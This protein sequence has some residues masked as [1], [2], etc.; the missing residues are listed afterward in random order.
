ML[1]TQAVD[2]DAEDILIDHAGHGRRNSQRPPRR[3][4]F[5]FQ[6]PRNRVPARI[7]DCAWVCWLVLR[8]GGHQKRQTT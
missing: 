8:Q 7:T 4:W 3:V 5:P 2:K 6:E 1:L